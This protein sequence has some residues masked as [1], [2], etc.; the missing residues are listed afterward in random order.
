[1]ALTDLPGHAFKRV[2]DEDGKVIPVVAV[3]DADGAPSTPVTL[4]SALHSDTLITT[5]TEVLGG[6]LT[7]LRM[8]R[9]HLQQITGE[10][11]SADEV[12]ESLTR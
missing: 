2:E 4:S 3:S 11:I 1:M 9:A 10:T 7:E 8:I 12:E 5:S 6:I